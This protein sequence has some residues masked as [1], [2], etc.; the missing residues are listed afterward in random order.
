MEQTE[1]KW[2]EMLEEETV[3]DV[4]WLLCEWG[5]CFICYIF[6]FLFFL[7]VRFGASHM[8][9]AVLC[10]LLL[11]KV[12]RYAQSTRCVSPIV[13]HMQRG[14]ILFGD[15]HLFLCLDGRRWN[16]WPLH[17]VQ[18]E[19]QPRVARLGVGTVG[20]VGAL[21]NNNNNDRASRNA[22]R[23]S[24]SREKGLLSPAFIILFMLPFCFFHPY[25]CSAASN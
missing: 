25:P 4:K 11:V 13:H 5:F 20:S 18:L 12:E 16:V 10:V 17:A 22:T 7:W 15:R 23:Q 19:C 3:N 8:R 6:C 2:E 14:E 9:L 1:T 24:P 21:N